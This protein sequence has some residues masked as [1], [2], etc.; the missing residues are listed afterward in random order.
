MRPAGMRR[1]A[2]R[3]VAAALLLLQQTAAW[4]APNR[5]PRQRLAPLRLNFIEQL[6]GKAEQQ[7]TAADDSPAT[8]GLV[9]AFLVDASPASR[10][11][12]ETFLARPDRPSVDEYLEGD[13]AGDERL[14][15]EWRAFTNVWRARVVSGSAAAAWA[16]QD[17]FEEFGDVYQLLPTAEPLAETV[18]GAGRGNVAMLERAVDATKTSALRPLVLAKRDAGDGGFGNILGPHDDTAADDRQTRWDV[19]LDPEDATVAA[20]VGE[21]LNGPVGDAFEELCGGLD[22]PL[23]EC[24]AIVAEPGAAPQPVHADTQW[25]DEPVL[26]TC[27]VALQDIPPELGPTRFLPGTATQDKHDAMDAALVDPVSPERAITSYCAGQPSLLALLEEGDASLY[28]SRLHHA[29]GPCFEATRCLF[30]VS[31]GHA[32]NENYPEPPQRSLG[33][34]V[35]ARGLTLGD[36]KERR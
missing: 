23:R 28:D 31:F 10:K 3:A 29:G 24:A 18:R 12:Y 6:L 4:T 26:F 9:E 16:Q 2:R 35:A 30:Y 17:A 32:A 7:T 27:F 33:E 13:C 19:F 5:N 22:A 11:A 25:T 36:L 15:L 8:L 14:R 20:V 1:S 21:L 34:A